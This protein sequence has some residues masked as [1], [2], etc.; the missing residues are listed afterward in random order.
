MRTTS[1]KQKFCRFLVVS[2]TTVLALAGVVTAASASPGP[3]PEDGRVPAEVEAA[4]ARDL[5]LTLAQTKQLA[6]RQE[7][8]VKLDASMRG[9][10][11]QAFAGSWFDSGSGS[12]VVATTD[13]RRAAEM[14]AAG[15]RVRVVKHSKAKLEAIKAELDALAGK[16]DGGRATTS[17]TPNAAVAGLTGWHIDPMTNTVVVTTLKGKP[18][19]QGWLTKFGDAVRVEYSDSAP[20]RTAEYMDGGDEINNRSCSAG[21]NLRNP[22]TGRGY[23]LTAGHCVTAGST[24]RGQG[25]VVFGPVLESYHAGV[26]DALVRN[27]NPGYWIQ[28]RWVDTNPSAGSIITVSG[29]SD[30][31]VGTAVCKSGITTKW[32]C[33]KITVKDETVNVDG[34]IRHGMTRHSACVEKGDS[35]GSNVALLSVYSPEG[36][37]SAAQ[38]RSDGTRLRCLQAFGL[39]NVSW[40]FPIADSL[41]WYG[42]RHG[43][44]M[45]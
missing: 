32:T 33:G 22:S 35:G 6:A 44:T 24:L 19:A 23:L 5:G 20:S 37:T 40:Y 21:F 42:P 29:W 10:L 27:D 16:V 12:L 3:R 4:L 7:A 36:V 9:R 43:V 1:Q 31:P 15:V 17:G 2:A 26:D 11:G 41:A 25:A 34:T 13:A 14:T 30:S 18:A 38:L 39:Q 45:W 28:G 8:A